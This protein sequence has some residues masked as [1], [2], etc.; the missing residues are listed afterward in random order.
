MSDDNSTAHHN[1]ASTWWRM[2]TGQQT[3]KTSIYRWQSDWTEEK[4]PL[5]VKVT[6]S[7]VAVASDDHQSWV[8]VKNLAAGGNRLE[9]KSLGPSHITLPQ[10]P[11]CFHPSNNMLKT[12]LCYKQCSTNADGWQ[13]HLRG[14]SPQPEPILAGGDDN[15]WLRRRADVDGKEDSQ[16]K[17]WLVLDVGGRKGE[18]GRMLMYTLQNT[19]MFS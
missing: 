16:R 18:C 14:W 7:G 19:E 4:K 12:H 2:F 17:L 8:P 6:S 9:K 3:T 10:P 5:S 13:A 11:P 1:F 15:S